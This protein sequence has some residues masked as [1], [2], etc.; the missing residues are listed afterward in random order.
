MSS[1]IFRKVYGS[2]VNY[3]KRRPA[4]NSLTLYTHFLTALFSWRMPSRHLHFLLVLYVR[5]SIS[6]QPMLFLLCFL[7]NEMP[8]SYTGVVSSYHMFSY[9]PLPEAVRRVSCK[10]K[11]PSGTRLHY[12]NNNGLQVFNYEEMTNKNLSCL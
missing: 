12:N 11:S 4:P 7:S 10:L 1:H 9:P 3:T 5:R 8:V 2:R 6:T